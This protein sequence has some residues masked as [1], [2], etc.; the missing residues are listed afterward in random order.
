LKVV[1][2]HREKGGEIRIS[3]RSL[4]QLDEICRRLK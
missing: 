2:T 4:D 1:I 3:Y